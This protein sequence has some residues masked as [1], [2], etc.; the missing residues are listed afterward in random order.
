MYRD[1]FGEFVHVY[2]G[3]KGKKMSLLIKLTNIPNNLSTFGKELNL[4]VEKMN[5]KTV[6]KLLD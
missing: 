5:K 3:L 4:S 6:E 2:C 1:Q